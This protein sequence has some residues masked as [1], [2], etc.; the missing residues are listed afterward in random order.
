M[1]VK[2]EQHKGNP[3]IESIVRGSQIETRRPVTTDDAE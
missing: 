2:D 3:E 1:A